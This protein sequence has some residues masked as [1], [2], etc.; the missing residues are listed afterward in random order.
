MGWTANWSPRS[1]L[2]KTLRWVRPF[3]ASA[4]NVMTRISPVPS[5][6]RS[7][8]GAWAQRNHETRPLPRPRQM[9]VNAL[10]WSSFLKQG[11]RPLS[12]LDMANDDFDGLDAPVCPFLGLAHDRRSHFTYAHP[13]HRCFAKKRPTTIDPGHQR[14]YCLSADYLSCDRY[15]AG[16]G[17]AVSR[18]RPEWRTPDGGTQARS[19]GDARS[20]TPPGSTVVVVVRAGDSMAKIAAKYG[21]TVEQIATASGLPVDAAVVDGTRLVIPLAPRTPARDPGVRPDPT[22]DGTRG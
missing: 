13:G 1:D 15:P 4:P 6:N 10:R 2:A 11:R 14:V 9:R 12:S 7:A 21:L 5:A 19:P 17:H 18:G 8:H 20:A 3:V 22:G 16:Q